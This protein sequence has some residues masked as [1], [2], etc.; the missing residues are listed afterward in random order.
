MHLCKKMILFFP[1]QKTGISCEQFDLIEQPYAFDAAARDPRGY[2]VTIMYIGLGRGLEPG[3]HKGMNNTQNPQFLPV[4][5]PPNLASD[6]DQIIAF[7]HHRLKALAASTNATAA[8]LPKYFTLSELQTAYEA[9]FC[10]KLDKRNFRKKI[11]SLG[12]LEETSKVSQ[13]GAHRPARLYKFRIAKLH[14]FSENF[15]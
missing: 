11:L 4:A 6:H 8:L 9:I 14:S 5:G 10:K 12:L 13:E 15:V 2:T 3:T 7:A 1:F